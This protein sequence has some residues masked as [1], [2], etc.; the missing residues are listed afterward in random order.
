MAAIFEF[1][2]TQTSD[3]IPTSL[4][5][6]PDPE[7]IGIAVGISLLS[8][9]KAEIYVI[10]YLLPILSRHIGYLVGVT[11]V[12]TPPSHS[13]VI[14]KKSHQSVS[15][16]SK[17]LRNGSKNSGLRSNF[18]PPLFNIWGLCR[19]HPFRIRI[20]ESIAAPPCGDDSIV[21]FTA[22]NKTFLLEKQQKS[23]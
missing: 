16:K 4:S 12:L 15:V 3:S 23:M 5:V 11:L 10:S 13:P 18:T 8:W 7:N 19:G 14:S 22:K 9:L 17:R 6:M 2:H 1:Q 20:H 21:S